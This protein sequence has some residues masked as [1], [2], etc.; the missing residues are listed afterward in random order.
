MV[1][2][3]ARKQGEERT[4]VATVHAPGDEDL[5]RV[6]ALG[7]GDLLDGR[8]LEEERLADAV[9]SKAYGGR[10]RKNEAS[11]EKEQTP[12]SPSEAATYRSRQ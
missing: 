11:A 12:G 5:T 10:S 1:R 9:V 7:L 8:V 3:R 2:W 4:R 6:G